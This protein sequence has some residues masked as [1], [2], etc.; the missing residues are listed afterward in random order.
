MDELQQFGHGGYAAYM[1][2]TKES[3]KECRLCR[4]CYL[5]KNT[6]LTA[7]G[8][9]ASAVVSFFE[10]NFGIAIDDQYRRA[11]VPAIRRAFFQNWAFC[12]YP[13]DDGVKG[14]VNPIDGDGCDY[15]E[16]A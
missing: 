5:N 11:L 4:W 8:L 10:N 12:D 9:K 3:H 16:E 15:Y 7:N 13:G 2:E 1:A 14:F 6:D